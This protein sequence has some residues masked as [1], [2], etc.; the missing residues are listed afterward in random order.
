[1]SRPEPVTDL[2]RAIGINDRFPLIRD[3][4]GGDGAAYE[5]A[6]DALNGF[7]NLDDCVIYMPSIMPGIPI[8]TGR[9]C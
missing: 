5:A 8:R 7:D 6:I 9:C 3:L 1:M 4:F 2:R